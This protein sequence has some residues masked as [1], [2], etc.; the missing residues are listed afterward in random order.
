MLLKSDSKSTVR[1]R[2]WDNTYIAHNMVLWGDGVRPA[3]NCVAG[4]NAF[5]S[6]DQNLAITYRTP[7]EAIASPS[8]SPMGH[9]VGGRGSVLAHRWKP[10][11]TY[12]SNIF[13][14]DDVT[15]GIA[16]R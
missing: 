14:E 6:K 3:T 16:N 8:S 13:Y 2:C 12:N 7:W 15:I 4:R 1:V 5:K 9:G 10:M 11:G